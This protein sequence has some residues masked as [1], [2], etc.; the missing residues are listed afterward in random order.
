MKRQMLKQQTQRTVLIRTLQERGFQCPS[1]IYRSHVCLPVSGSLLFKN[2][3]KLSC[4]HPRR[5]PT[6]DRAAFLQIRRNG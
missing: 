3:S 6:L 2:R 1:T 4:H 5:L